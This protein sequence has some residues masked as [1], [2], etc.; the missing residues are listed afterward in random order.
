MPG[1][2]LGARGPRVSGVSTARVAVLLFSETNPNQQPGVGFEQNRYTSARIVE[3]VARPVPDGRWLD[4]GFGNGS[5]LFTA[6]VW[7]FE[8]HG[9]DLRPPTP[10]RADGGARLRAAPVL[11]Q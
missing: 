6:E 7:D 11:G 5:L 8:P 10:L 2:A 3:R 4:V 9:L 1:A